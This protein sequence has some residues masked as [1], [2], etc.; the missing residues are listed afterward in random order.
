[1]CRSA[2]NLNKPLHHG[3]TVSDRAKLP[4]YACHYD[5]MVPKY[6]DKAELGYMDTDSLIYEIKTDDVYED[7]RADVPMM[8]GTSAF[9]E[10][11]PAGLPIM[12]K[13]VPGLMKDEAC[14]R[15][16]TKVISLSAKQYTYEIEGY[17]G[18]CGSE[19][20]SGKCDNEGC[21]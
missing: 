15:N 17:D 7:I 1:M 4:M 12:K 10:G 11:H 5:Y 14:G 21:I 8:F 2:V 6:R 19:I 13:Q 20:C 18:M 16:I 3:V 9:P